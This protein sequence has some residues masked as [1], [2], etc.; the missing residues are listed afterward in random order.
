MEAYW[1]V[2]AG[3]VASEGAGVTMKLDTFDSG[4]METSEI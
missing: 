2:K 4:N 1:S 3:S